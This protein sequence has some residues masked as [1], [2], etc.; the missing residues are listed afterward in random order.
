MVLVLRD[1]DT[2]GDGTLDERLWVVQDANYNVTA[3]FD[4]SGNVVERYVYDPFGQATV[5]D[6]NWNVLS[7]STFAWVYLHQGGRFDATSGLYHFRF[8][9]YSPTLGRWSSLDPIRYAAGDVNLYRTVFNAPTVFTDPSGLAGS[10]LSEKIKDTFDFF[11]NIGD[12]LKHLPAATR[13]KIL[14]LALDVAQ[15][16][17]DIGG[18]FEP[19]PF[20]D[21][22]SGVISAGR[23]DWIGALL[24]GAGVIPFAGDVAKVGKIAKYIKSL[25]TLVGLAKESQPVLRALAP[26][27]RHL[28]DLLKGMPLEKAPSWLDD[29]IGPITKLRDD[30]GKLIDP[31]TIL[32]TL[33]GRIGKTGPIKEVPDA[34]A[35]DDLF[36]LLTSGGK[37]VPSPPT[38][39]GIT[40]QLPDGTKIR[41]R[42]DSKSGGPTLDIDLPDGTYIKVHIQLP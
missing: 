31:K 24:S 7:A 40:I 29:V 12:H 22:T 1:R 38:Y 32:D 15:L 19:T 14:D 42:P 9:D 4:N 11:K 18:I 34:K 28:Y 16:A 5:L 33:P 21:I 20:C 23:G 27:L 10:S 2:T 17:L 13:A 39:K 35:L 37:T 26:G 25:E 3:L 6:A 36:E 8:R 30:L 41:R